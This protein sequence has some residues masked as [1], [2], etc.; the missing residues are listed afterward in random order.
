MQLMVLFM[1]PPHPIQDML[2]IPE[3]MAQSMAQTTGTK[4]NV[5]DLV[6]SFIEAVMVSNLV[7]KII[8]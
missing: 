4:H 1:H 2:A 8:K 6:W 3:A 5:S 7:C